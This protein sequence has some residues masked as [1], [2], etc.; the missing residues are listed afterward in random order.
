MADAADLAG[1]DDGGDD[2]LNAAAP[3]VTICGDVKWRVPQGRR[4]FTR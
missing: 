1:D 3:S 4:P 2:A